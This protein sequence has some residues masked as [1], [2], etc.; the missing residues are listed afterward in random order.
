MDSDRCPTTGELDCQMCSGEYCE[1]HICRP[2]ECDTAERHMIPARVVGEIGSGNYATAN[3]GKLTVTQ[4]EA[5]YEEMSQR[6]LIEVLSELLTLRRQT[7]VL[8]GDI[9]MPTSKC[10]GYVGHVDDETGSKWSPCL[11]CAAGINGHK[12]TA[13]FDEL[14]E[15]R[16]KYSS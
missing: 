2:C 5:F 14:V 10:P 11:I 4:Q 8:N 3:R 16:K 15:Y 1:T 12:R 13:G 9:S 7:A 6:P